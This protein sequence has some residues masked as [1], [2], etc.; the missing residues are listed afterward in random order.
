MAL[1]QETANIKPDQGA[2]LQG[3]ALIDRYAA[4]WSAECCRCATQ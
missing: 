4:P 3:A 1:I 2:A